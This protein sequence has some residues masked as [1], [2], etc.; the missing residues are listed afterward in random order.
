MRLRAAPK[1][2]AVSGSVAGP[3]S[4]R[5]RQEVV[6]LGRRVGPQPAQRG[7]RLAQAGQGDRP[8]VGPVERDDPGQALVEHDGEGVQVG[9]TVDQVPL[10]LLG[11]D[12]LGG[13]EEDALVAELVDGQHR[14]GDPEVGQLH[15]AFGRQQHVA[16]LHVAVDDAGVVRRVQ[17]VGQARAEQDRLV[18]LQPAP[19]V[20][21]LAE[22]LARHVLHDDGLVAGVVHGVEDGDDA[23]VVDPCHRHGLALEA[24]DEGAVV[25]QVGMQQLQR[26]LT[27]QD[28]VRAEPH[29]GHAADGEAAVEAVPAGQALRADRWR[30][31][32]RE[33]GGHGR[34]GTLVRR[35]G[36]PG[37]INHPALPRSRGDR[38]PPPSPACARRVDST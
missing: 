17:G 19:A 15:P 21:Q 34:D 12:V 24:L 4:Q 32:R 27:A 7:C 8:L 2:A 30:G 9:P 13:A 37:G 18:D 38:W 22:V 33:R 5:R 23:R 20:E 31:R 16:R 35:P 11:R 6:E 25:G 14:R 10:H 1:I 36:R 29:L 3:G 28:L 26:H